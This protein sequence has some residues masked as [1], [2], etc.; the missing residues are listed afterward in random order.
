MKINSTGLERIKLLISVILLITVCFSIFHYTV[1]IREPWFGELSAEHA[2][3]LTG[4][5]VKFATNWYQEGPLN[6][7]FAMLENPKSVEFQN[8]SSRAPYTS[9]PP[10]TIIPIYLISE[11]QGHKPTVATVMDYNLFNHFLIALILGLTIF[12][13]FRQLKIDMINSFL[14]SLIPII[15]ELLLPGPIYWFQNV[16]FSDQAV[17]LLF[18]LYIFLEILRDGM[19]GKNLRILNII[20]N[21]VLFIGFL[22]DWLFVFIA[23]TVYIKRIIDGEIVLRRK[24]SLAN[25]HSFLND[26]LKYWIV[27]IIAVALFALQDYLLGG[28]SNTITE[29]LIRTAASQ[30]GAAS[31]KNG[32][33]IFLWYISNNY[34]EI[35]LILLL[36]SAAIFLLVT[37]I[38]LFKIYK[39]QNIGFDVFKIKKILYLIGMFIIPCVLQIYFF[40]NHSVVHE[41]SVLK[42][43]VS[44]STVPL[45]L[46]PVLIFFL[47]ENFMVKTFRSKFIILRNFFN[48]FKINPRLFIIFLLAFSATLGYVAYEFPQY[49]TLFPTPNNTYGII[50]NSIQQNTG[51]N[52]VVFSPDIEIP[53]NPPQQ[54]SYSMKRVYQINSTEDIKNK[55]NLLTGNYN[56]VVMFLKPPSNYWEKILGNSTYVKDGRIYY[57]RINPNNI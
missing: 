33:N 35:G 31:L 3:W 5:T 44:I 38:I 37:S 20:Q 51:Y 16:F 53:T 24:M 50:G 18:V 42:F 21:L 49:K 41:F 2:Q 26:S 6:L 8:I 45:V 11:L 48:K 30:T 23:L 47:T 15:L 22:T 40:K 43:S 55:T 13:F 25:I 36:V 34:G 46:L 14:F 56:I 12:F 27:P 19:I 4:S 39:K 32:L 7:K 54:L 1:E 17:I 28:I 57:Y 52:D 10:G 29:F 9:Y